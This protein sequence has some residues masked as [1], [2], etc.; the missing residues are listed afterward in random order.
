MIRFFWLFILTLGCKSTEPHSQ[1]QSLVQDPAT[2]YDGATRERVEAANSELTMDA[3]K[4][5][6][7]KKKK[8]YPIVSLYHSDDCSNSLITRI[9]WNTDCEKLGESVSLKIW[10][11]EVNGNCY[12]VNDQSFTIGCKKYRKIPKDPIIFYYSDDCS[13]SEEYFLEKTSTCQQALQDI[14]ADQ[15]I[16]AVK[17]N[18]ECHNIDDTNFVA[19]CEQWLQ[20]LATENGN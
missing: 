17:L 14:S 12:N 10:G 19:A 18:G 16:W 8:E 3:N 11:I 7:E 2:Y 15:K 6:P 4:P 20:I 1:T 5:K 13:S 9:T